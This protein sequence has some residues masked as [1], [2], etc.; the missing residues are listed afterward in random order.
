MTYTPTSTL[1]R[2]SIKNVSGSWNVKSFV[3]TWVSLLSDEQLS[4]AE[5]TLSGINWT[6][7]SMPD[8]IAIGKIG[9]KNLQGRITLSSITEEGYQQIVSLFG[10]TVFQPD[11]A[12]VIDAPASMFLQGP[13]VVVAGASDRFTATVFPVTSL[14]ILYL[15][16][17]NGQLISSSTDANGKVYRTYGGV[18]L[19]EESGIISVDNNIAS[20]VNL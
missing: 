12:F 2:L 9:T 10:N 5:L 11:A 13:T 19:Y 7:V 17:N 6:N 4:Q 14:S 20:D 8:V 18:T 3:T 16:Y 15:L 1:K